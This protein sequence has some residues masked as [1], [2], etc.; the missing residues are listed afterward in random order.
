MSDVI[1]EEH[2]INT[3]PSVFNP[4]SDG[5]SDLLNALW[6]KLQKA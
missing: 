3:Y 5:H 4:E 2:F 6:C 1:V